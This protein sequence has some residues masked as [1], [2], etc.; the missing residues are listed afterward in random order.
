MEYEKFEMILNQKIFTDTKSKLIENIAGHPE[1]YVGLFRPTKPKAKLFQNIFHSQESRFGDAFEEIIN[2]YLEE[3][4]CTK[5]CSNVSINN[6]M[7]NIDLYFNKGDKT[8]V[9]EQKIR[10]D[11]DSTKKQGQ[12]DDFKVKLEKIIEQKSVDKTC[13]GIFFVDP[14]LKKIKHIMKNKLKK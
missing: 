10:D 12:W 6:K 11:H 1:R 2:A 9:V 8:F 3:N 14:S 5:E 7:K 13:G 4:G